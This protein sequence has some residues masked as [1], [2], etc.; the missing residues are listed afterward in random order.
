MPDDEMQK[1]SSK[2]IVGLLLIILFPIFCQ[3]DSS[4]KNSGRPV[5]SQNSSQ[6]II[7]SDVLDTEIPVIAYVGQIH[8][9]EFTRIQSIF[10]ETADDG[11]TYIYF[12]FEGNLYYK[13]T[14]TSAD[15]GSFLDL[16]IV[17]SIPKTAT[18]IQYS[19]N[20]FERYKDYPVYHS[21]KVSDN[22]LIECI[23]Y[24]GCIDTDRAN[25][26]IKVNDKV[27]CVISD[28]GWITMFSYDLDSDNENEIIIGSRKLCKGIFDIYLIKFSK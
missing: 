20:D 5:I 23:T 1:Y 7:D 10:G 6:I 13:M 25:I 18:H 9:P 3:G 8:P 4:N 2:L 24:V 26:H 14:S 27:L 17:D 11:S 22:I 19:Q 16:G 12:K 15:S 21:W 28:L